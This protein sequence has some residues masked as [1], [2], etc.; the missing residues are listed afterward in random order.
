ME[1]RHQMAEANRVT[2]Q[3]AAIDIPGKHRDTA[4]TPQTAPFPIFAGFGI[5]VRFEEP[6][7]DL[8]IG[9]GVRFAEKTVKG[10]PGRE[11]TYC[12]KLEAV[13]GHVGAGEVN[14][15]D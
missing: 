4:A 13:E 10:L 1:A 15:R 3:A 14:R 5:E 11:L 9:L 7:I 12:R 6:P 2:E 8:H